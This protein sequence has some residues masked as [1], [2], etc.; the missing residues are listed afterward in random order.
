EEQLRASAFRIQQLL[1]Q[2]KARGEAPD[3]NIALPGSWS[4]FIDWSETHLAGR[5]VLSPRARRGVRSPDFEDVELAA[6]CLL[7]LANEYRDRRMGGSE[8][9]LRDRAVE[10]G[11]WNA[12]CGSDQFD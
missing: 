9:S 11:I 6:R 10:D 2:L 3:A 1:N 4:N 7:W 12:H 8:G 5:V